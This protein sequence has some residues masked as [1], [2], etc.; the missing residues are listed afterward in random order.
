MTSWR[1]PRGIEVEVIRLDR[2][3]VFKVTKTGRHG[4]FLLG[5]CATIAQVTQHVDLADLVEVIPFPS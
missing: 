5:Y 3:E 4:R 1:G 2:R